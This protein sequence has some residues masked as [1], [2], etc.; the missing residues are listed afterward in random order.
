MPDKSQW[1]PSYL[2]T[3]LAPAASPELML[4]FFFINLALSV[5]VAYT[6]V[7]ALGIRFLKNRKAF[8][9][10]LVSIGT[11]VPVLGNMLAI[12]YVF[13]LRRQIH[14][15]AAVDVN[16]YPAFEYSRLAPVK[17]V[18]YGTGWAN[19]RL[20][21]SDFEPEVRQQALISISR[22][23]PRDVNLI[24][25]KLLSDDSEEL[26][27]CA[28]SLL[29]KQQDYLHTK[30]SHLLKK[31]QDI[32]LPEKRAFV[33]KQL[34]L[35]YWE[36]VYQNLSDEDIRKILLER[37]RFYANLALDVLFKD[38]TLW[39][40]LSRISI[41]EGKVTQGIEYLI[42]ASELQAPQ[43]K[44]IPYLAELA[45]QN[46]DYNAVKQYL[47]SDLSLQYIFKINKIVKFWCQI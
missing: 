1:L 32:V 6:L 24:Y 34:A 45:Y 11:F 27:V 36:L 19:L 42:K 28:F 30:I 47:K 3:L 22:G 38:T 39:I 13:F 5:L 43:S 29:E 40:L 46:K 10:L 18:A 26:R 8:F 2:G 25:S 7:Y 37:S 21:S 14:K 20:Q 12:A 4:T 44:V 17:T 35:L 41:E 15:H 31:Y 9:R 23:S 33:A 16:F